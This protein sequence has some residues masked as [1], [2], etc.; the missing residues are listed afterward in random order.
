[1]EFDTILQAINTSGFP[2][3]MCIVFAWYIYKTNKDN[4]ERIDNI[5][6]KHADEISAVTQALNN[7]TIALTQLAERLADNEN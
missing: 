4:N 5:N 2:I 6:S 7:N 3:V 1:M